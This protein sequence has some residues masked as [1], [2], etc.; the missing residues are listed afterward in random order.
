MNAT[1]EL[2]LGGVLYVYDRERRAT[3]CISECQSEAIC[4]QGAR[5]M[6]EEGDRQERWVEAVPEQDAGRLSRASKTV[7]KDPREM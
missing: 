7:N 3:R 1:A 4:R 6:T 5:Y 2:D